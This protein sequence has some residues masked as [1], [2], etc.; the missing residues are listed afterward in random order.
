MQIS[1]IP[2]WQRYQAINGPT[3]PGPLTWS[4]I[5]WPITEPIHCS[6]KLLWTQPTRANG[7]PTQRPHLHINKP[8]LAM[9]ILS[10]HSQIDI[11]ECM[12]GLP[13]L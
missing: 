1:I 4:E 13:V 2:S 7:Y 8:L 12:L 5:A 10:W 11:G 3:R 9:K 6:R